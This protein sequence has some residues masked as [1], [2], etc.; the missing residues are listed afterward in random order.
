MMIMML[1]ENLLLCEKINS[2]DSRVSTNTS[3]TSRSMLYKSLV[4]HNSKYFSFILLQL[5]MKRML[6]K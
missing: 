4:L 2:F 6:E 3:N 5:E 1:Y